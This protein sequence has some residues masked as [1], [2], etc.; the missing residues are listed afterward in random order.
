MSNNNNNFIIHFYLTQQK[1]DSLAVFTAFDPQQR[2]VFVTANDSFRYLRQS[3][4]IVYVHQ[5]RPNIEDIVTE[6]DVVGICGTQ[7]INRQI[8]SICRRKGKKC[9]KETF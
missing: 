3:S 9:F 6:S 1:Y 4:V 7:E 5:G 2:I 8:S